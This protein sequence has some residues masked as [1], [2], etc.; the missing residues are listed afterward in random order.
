MKALSLFFVLVVAKLITLAGRELPWSIWTPS[1][2]FWQDA[3]VALVFAGIDFAFRRRP[4]VGATLYWL[5]VAYAAIN[6]PIAR[7]LGSPFTWQMAHA[8]GGASPTRLPIISRQPRLRRL[9]RSLLAAWAF[10]AA[11]TTTHSKRP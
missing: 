4:A 2:L 3:L 6:V 10:G 5:I 8:T 11:H 7:I 1:H 9:Q